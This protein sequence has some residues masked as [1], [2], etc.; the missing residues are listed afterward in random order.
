MLAAYLRIAAHSATRPRKYPPQAWRRCFSNSYAMISRASR[1]SHSQ[2]THYTHR[3]THSQRR[4][5]THKHC[6][7]KNEKSPQRRHAKADFAGYI[8][9][10]M[11]EVVRDCQTQ[12]R[13]VVNAR[14]E[15]RA[16]E[17][18]NAEHACRRRA[19]SW[20]WCSNLWRAAKQCACIRKST[21]YYSNIYDIKYKN[22]YIYHL[23]STFTKR[24]MDFTGK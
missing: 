12:S 16:R 11:R 4:N 8:S 14:V 3:D 18:E 23:S 6:W 9:H 20:Q 1:R 13:D 5:T 19:I 15:I 2:Q 21:F 24:Q 10:T 22:M 7:R 17:A